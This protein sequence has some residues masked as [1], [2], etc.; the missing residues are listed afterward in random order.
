MSDLERKKEFSSEGI[1]GDF[2]T[3]K[4]KNNQTGEEQDKTRQRGISIN[5]ER[6]KKKTHLGDERLS[7]ICPQWVEN[8]GVVMRGSR[9]E[10]DRGGKENEC[11]FQRKVKR[12]DLGERGGTK[13]AA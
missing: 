3:P 8:G 4:K 10:E 7:D 6:K 5:I 11:P 1:K 12:S 13:K 9:P 2:P